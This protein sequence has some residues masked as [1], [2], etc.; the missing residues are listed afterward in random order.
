MPTPTSLPRFCACAF[1]LLL[2][3]AFAADSLNAQDAPAPTAAGAAAD[4]KRHLPGFLDLYWEPA[5][6]RMEISVPRGGQDAIYVNSLAAGIGSNDIGL[7]RGQIGDTRYVHFEVH[8]DHVLIVQPNVDYRAVTDNADERRAVEEAFA[9]SVLAA[10]P[11]VATHDDR[12][13]ADLTD[14]ATTDVHGVARRLAD[15]GQ[16]TYSLDK[17]RSVVLGEAAASFPRNTLLESLLT[18]SGS[19]PGDYVRQ[20]TPTPEAV[21][22]RI[23]HEFI[24]PPDAG[25][26]VR[27]YHP[28][29]GGFS[30]SYFDFATPLSSDLVKHTVVRH[31]LQRDPQTGRTVEPIVYYVD[32][33]APEPIRS[34]LLEG[35]SFWTE[36]FAAA[37]F[38]DGFRVEVLPEGA[39][40]LD[41]R[42][43]VIQ[44]VHRATRGWSY[45]W[46]VIDPRT[47]EIIKGHVTLGSQRVRQDQ[48]IAEALTAPFTDSGDG[49]TAAREL[50]LARLRQ[51]AAHE[52]GHTL[53][54]AHNFA[55]S[56][57]QDASVMDYPHPKLKLDANGD[58]SLADA[59]DTGAGRWDLHAIAYLYT[60]FD[61]GDE[62]AG[63]QRIIDNGAALHYL[64]DADARNPA[65]SATPGAHL[66][67]NGADPLLRLAELMAV[68]E[69]ALDGFSAA[70]LRDDRQLYEAEARL[71]P[72][73][74]L[75]RYQVQAVVKLI[76]G[77]HYEYGL[78]RDAPAAPAPVTAERQ[79]AAIDAILGTVATSALRLAPEV[80]ATLHPPGPSSDRGP[81][82]FTHHTG[83]VFDPLAPARAAAQ[84][85]AGLLLHPTRAQRL[86][87]QHM[88]DPTLPGLADALGRISALVRVDAGDDSYDTLL[89]REV[90]WTFLR[91]LQRLATSDAAS[92]PVRT[93][94]VAALARLRDWAA[95]QSTAYG[96]RLSTE[97]TAFLAA[98]D[99]EHLP[100]RHPIPPGSPI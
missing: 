16:G 29:S 61:D 50:A 45:G 35:A 5:S 88:L 97:L 70:V 4:E 33:G 6:G 58:V 73:Y 46:G 62:A 20:V 74:L 2:A 54:L 55:A 92:E 15:T 99:G 86:V 12:V 7:D 40:P 48:L 51:L 100:P 36:A 68:R 83:R 63:L 47:G 43:N 80:L 93:D 98:P 28:R 23:R 75:H 49:G 60:Q 87:N 19:A 57:Q 72:V 96:Q 76:G 71:V 94:A 41:I 65:T 14:F 34:A 82:H 77:V 56:G 21:S 22:V 95:G 30:R 3:S 64:S 25:F 66:W 91:E 27:D 85:A 11:I 52:V 17:A 38:P 42:Y 8:G 26:Q 1:V 24:A 78:R 81:E 31:R 89:A 53:G 67:D 10:L 79:L 90:A 39:S 44:W 59:Y 18:F 9:T 37:G 13:V 84:H 32:N 69:R